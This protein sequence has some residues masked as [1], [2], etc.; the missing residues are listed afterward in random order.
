MAQKQYPWLSFVMLVDAVPSGS[1]EAM[2]DM[3]E[4]IGGLV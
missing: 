3:T 2:A 1:H 4:I